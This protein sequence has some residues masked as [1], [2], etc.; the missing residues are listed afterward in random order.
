MCETREGGIPLLRPQI[1][2]QILAEIIQV[3]AGSVKVSAVP[4]EGASLKVD[5]QC[6]CEAKRMAAG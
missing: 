4:R 1:K 3:P 6:L 5:N 2:T